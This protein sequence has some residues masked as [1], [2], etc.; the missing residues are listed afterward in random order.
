MGKSKKIRRLVN[1]NG[2][3]RWIT[4]DSEQEY[5]DNLLLALGNTQTIENDHST[6]EEK[7]LF[8]TY[9]ENWFEVFSK[10]NIA[11]VTAKTYERQL[12]YHLFPAFEGM[13][14]EDI[15]PTDVQRLFNNINGAKETKIK[16]RNVLNMVFQ[17]AIEDELIRKN[18]LSSKSIRITGLPSNGIQPYS[19]DQMKFLVH[20]IP[21]L[22]NPQDR[23]YLSLHTLHPLRPE[24][25]LGLQWQDIDFENELISVER[26]VTHP[27]RNQPHI[28]P[29]KTLASRRQMDLVPQIIPYLVK[30][31]P[32]EFVL[33]GK[34]PLTYT[35]V[36]KM[37]QRI[38]RETNFD[39]AITPRR[40]RTTVLTDLYD[41]TKDI[42]QA[43]AAAGHTTATMTL[44]HYV[45]G[46]QQRKNSAAPIASVY[47][48]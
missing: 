1:I 44:K 40:F 30:G 23:M 37:C 16:V 31:D 29:P 17:Q 11:L 9:A 4:G 14:I 22:E 19:V 41:C 8:R 6:Q 36:R 20:A 27:Y 13:N 28:A 34:L 48:L 10:P 24:E 32:Q 18:P 42:K 12:R 38:Q 47:G 25:V 43:Q 35:Q 45:K 33:G 2:T 39:E 5:A 15:S 7:H 46:R 26:A 21:L 3:K